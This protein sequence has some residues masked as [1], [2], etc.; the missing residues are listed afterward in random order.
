MP[1]P[2]RLRQGRRKTPTWQAWWTC[3][4]GC[5]VETPRLPCCCWSCVSGT[6]R[7][8]P[9]HDLTARPAQERSRRV[10]LGSRTTWTLARSDCPP[11]SDARA[12]ATSD[13]RFFRV[14]RS[15]FGPVY[16]TSPSPSI[17]HGA[18]NLGIQYS[19]CTP[20]SR[21]SLFSVFLELFHLFCPL[22]GLTRT[23]G[24]HGC[25]PKKHLIQCDAPSN[26]RESKIWVGPSCNQGGED[27]P[28]PSL[29]SLLSLFTS[30][31]FKAGTLEDSQ[32]SS[33]IPP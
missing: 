11:A 6:H 9:P 5:R 8:A 24:P 33:C 4:V 22:L 31:P 13:L 23:R 17:I 3:P 18:A 21:G 32:S 26:P 28:V 15:T 29:H 7:S 19:W 30:A 16:S 10:F 25:D 12:R 20:C 2:P 14:R 1:G 27:R